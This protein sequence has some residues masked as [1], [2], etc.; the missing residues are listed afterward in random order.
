ME[1]LE[2]LLFY[3]TS[4]LKNQLD[5]LIV[6][7]LAPIDKIN[8]LIALYINRINK[9]LELFKDSRNLIWAK[10]RGTRILMSW[11]KISGPR[12]NLILWDC[13]TIMRRTKA[14]IY[15]KIE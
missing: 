11:K 9:N 10:S 8:K 2:S 4:D 15:G 14:N 7:E 5:H 12:L 13:A 6:E 3:R 1:A